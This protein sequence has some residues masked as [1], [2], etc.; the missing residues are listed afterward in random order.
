MSSW[1]RKDT[2]IVWLDTWWWMKGEHRMI[3]HMVVDERWT[4]YDW[5][6]GAG[7]K[8]NIVW[9]DTWCWMKGEHRMIG[10]M[11]VDEKWTSY[12]WTHG[13][14]WK[15]DIVWLDT[16]WWVKGGHRMI[17]HMVVDERWTSVT[18]QDVDGV[19]NTWCAFIQPNPQ[20]KHFQYWHERSQ[21]V[22]RGWGRIIVALWWQLLNIMVDFRGNTRCECSRTSH[23]FMAVGPFATR[24]H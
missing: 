7:W 1:R 9:L 3:G 17:G 12:D 10:H 2:N 13:G 24:W 6:H 22:C 4:S 15:V 21:C 23:D 19:L 16:W 14:G 8:V 5:T 18:V 11:V 20:L